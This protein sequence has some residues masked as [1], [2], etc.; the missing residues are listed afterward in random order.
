MNYDQMKIETTKIPGCVI[1]E[2]QVFGDERGFF[3]ETFRASRFVEHG[4]PGNFVQDNFS[5]SVG[6]TLRGLHYQVNRPQ[7]K[8][9]QVVRG[10]VFDVA[11]D[12]REDSASF[13][14]WTGLFLSEADQKQFY[15]PPGC[16]HGFYVVSDSADFIYK[17]TEQY[18]PENERVL[19]W[20]DAEINIEWP[21]LSEPI[22]SQKDRNGTPFSNCETFPVSPS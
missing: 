14:K 9:V 19:L 10:E 16:A 8:I 7:G 2:P 17:C 12:L 1:V 6:G 5:R 20:N 22:L 3:M 4:L 21:L 15:I 13:G 11:V 18:D